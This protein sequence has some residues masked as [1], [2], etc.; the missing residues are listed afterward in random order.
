[1]PFSNR[2]KD[3]Q[4]NVNALSRDATADVKQPGPLREIQSSSELGVDGVEFGGELGGDAI[5]RVD[6]A[7]WIDQR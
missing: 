1:M 4:Q 3:V 7:A 6:Q 5:R 2:G